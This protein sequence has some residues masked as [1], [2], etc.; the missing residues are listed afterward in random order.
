[1][2]LYEQRFRLHKEHRFLRWQRSLWLGRGQ[3]L[4]KGRGST[5]AGQLGPSIIAAAAVVG[6]IVLKHERGL[7]RLHAPLV[8]CRRLAAVAMDLH[9]A[10]HTNAACIWTSTG[11]AF[12]CHLAAYARQRRRCGSAV[13][14]WRQLMRAPVLV[15]LLARPTIADGPRR[16][17]SAYE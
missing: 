15:P 3:R 4:V 2:I 13:R 16:V 7:A 9:V 1:M 8:A 6:V 11:G 17:S 10:N 14:P 5:Q 12:R